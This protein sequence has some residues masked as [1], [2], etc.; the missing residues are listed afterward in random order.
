MEYM[1]RNLR[2]LA[3]FCMQP[4]EK[5][6]AVQ[7]E[8]LR[9][10]IEALE[11]AIQQQPPTP[12]P[13]GTSDQDNSVSIGVSDQQRHAPT[14]SV[15]PTDWSEL[16]Q[17]GELEY[18]KRPNVRSGSDWAS[19]TAR[20]WT[21]AGFGP[22]DFRDRLVVDVGAGSRLRTLYFEGARIAAIEPLGE[23]FISEV[24]WQ[25]LDSA[26][27]LYCR[28]AENFIPE[29]EGRASLIV[30]I[31]ALDHG[32]NFEQAIKNLRRY[33]TDDGVAYLSFDQHVQ[34]DEM[35]PLVL[36]K[37]I[38]DQVMVDAGFKIDRFTEA[39]RYHGGEGLQALNY[40]LKPDNEDSKPA[41]E[42]GSVD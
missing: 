11:A 14:T 10:Q 40:W 36:T 16:A 24:E 33:L 20:K 38:V 4:T 27:E 15:K 7:I 28:P 32:Y 9:Q 8:G 3:G 29:L 35:H 26:D 23:S 39:G 18:H 13:T 21:N 25:D 19:D 17:P 41:P 5:R 12:V 37:S 6:L 2:R 42:L 22:H 1:R 30:S 31:N 34:P